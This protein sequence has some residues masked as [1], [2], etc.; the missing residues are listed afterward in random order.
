MLNSAEKV[1]RELNQKEC[2]DDWFD[3]QKRFQSACRKCT[4]EAYAK[5]IRETEQRVRNEGCTCDI[6]IKSLEAD[7]AKCR[8]DLRLAEGRIEFNLSEWNKDNRFNGKLFNSLND[9]L[10]KSEERIHQLEAERD[11]AKV[12]AE[13]YRKSQDFHICYGEEQILKCEKRITALTEGLRKYG[14]HTKK[15]KKQGMSIDLAQ[16][17]SVGDIDEQYSCRCGLTKLIEGE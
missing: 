17:M 4:I 3:G 8:D 16:Q 1:Y 6:R 12:K 9:K 7:L 2:P 5:A 11:E 13:Q 15:C 10:T 14:I